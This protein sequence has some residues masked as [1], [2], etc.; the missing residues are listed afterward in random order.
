MRLFATCLMAM[1]IL[2]HGAQAQQQCER[3]LSIGAWNI[4]YLGSKPEKPQKSVDIAT[5][6][7][8]SKVEVLALSEISHTHTKG[9]SPR[10]QPLD[11]AFA[12]L[13]KAGAN[14]RYEIFPKRAGSR[15]PMTDQWTGVAWNGQSVTA[16]GAPAPLKI[17]IDLTRET[18]IRTEMGAKEKV[19]IFSR[20]PH[21]MKFSA[22]PGKTDFAVVPV[23]LKSN[24]DSKAQLARAYEIELLIPALADYAGTAK[25]RD[26]IVLGDTNMET[27]NEDAGKRF[28]DA[29]YR[30][31]NRADQKTWDFSRPYDRIWVSTSQPETRN[32]CSGNGTGALDFSLV[33]PIAINLTQAK[34][35]ERLSDHLMV[36][37]GICVQKDDD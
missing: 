23:H 33:M 8:A 24:T 32:T 18:N 6:I 15:P 1:G 27:T 28:A 20:L 25:E 16:V 34:F 3:V 4:K 7:A 9:G 30:D 11:D 2:A 10:N 31:C 29:G 14:W 26:I 21:V 17:N 5:Y 37:A 13:N 22:G 35:E 36:K 12:I 19:I